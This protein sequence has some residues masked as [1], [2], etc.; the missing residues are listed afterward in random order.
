[1]K[2][3]ID[4]F[5]TPRRK[6]RVQCHMDGISIPGVGSMRLSNIP[7]NLWGICGWLFT[8]GNKLNYGLILSTHI[9]KAENCELDNIFGSPTDIYLKN[10][11]G[12]T[13]LWVQNTFGDELKQALNNTCDLFLENKQPGSY[14]QIACLCPAPLCQKDLCITVYSAILYGKNVSDELANCVKDFISNFCKSKNPSPIEWLIG[15][16]TGIGIVC[17]V[18]PSCIYIYISIRDTYN[19]RREGFFRCCYEFFARINL[20]G[21]EPSLSNQANQQPEN[22]LVNPIID[23]IIEVSEQKTENNSTWCCFGR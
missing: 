9:V 10:S 8:L 19:R 7:N 18:I 2:I 20:R 3:G 6:S 17:C 16:A 21:E 14:D 13:S 5:G 11:K 1:M 15:F 22:Y 4:F 23:D 12:N